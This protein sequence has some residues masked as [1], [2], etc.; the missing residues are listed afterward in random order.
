MK[1]LGLIQA[2]NE[3]CS[4]YRIEAFRPFLADLNIDLEIIGLRRGILSRL[5]DLRKAKNADLV[6]L[7]RKLLP[8]W[9]ISLLRNWAKRLVFDIDDAVYQRDSNSRKGP[10]SWARLARFR[11]TA[12]DSDAV[13]VGNDFLRLVTSKWIPPERVVLMPTCIDLAKYQPARHFRQN[14]DARLVWIGQ[15]TTL[16]TLG[17]AGGLL[18]AIAHRL[19]NL[20]FRQICNRSSY[21]AALNVVFRPWSSET[22]TAELVEGDIGIA[23][24]PDDTWSMGKCGLKVLQYMAA[25]LPVVANPVGVH[26]EMI[27][28]GETGF[29]AETP[30]EWAEAVF[31]LANNPDL[32]ARFGAAGRRL[33]ESRY[34]TT[35]WGSHFAAILHDFIH[36]SSISYKKAG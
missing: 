34:S 28:H 10:T 27:V 13:F 5:G 25:G 21:F 2:E 35:A 20:E 17:K 12:Q 15:A 31:Q 8:S 23:Y 29:L 3:V 4:R 9:E 16:E 36:D 1:V 22:E 33:V 6:I 26:R 7:Q 19:P 30:G 18:G 11:A 32:R 14:L 24:M